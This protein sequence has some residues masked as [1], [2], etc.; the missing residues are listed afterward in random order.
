[1][2]SIYYMVISTMKQSL[3]NIVISIIVLALGISQIF[4]YK[5]MLEIQEPEPYIEYEE[6][7]TFFD[8]S[9]E[10]GLMEALMYFNVQHP[11]IV[12][13]QAVLETGNFNSRICKEYNN[14]FGLYDSRRKQYYTFNHWSESVVAYVKYIQYRYLPPKDYYK[15]LQD[16]GYAE[17]PKYIDKLKIIVE[18]KTKNLDTINGKERSTRLSNK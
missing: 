13:A 17:D 9:P 18:G 7:I 12:Y 8:K 11:H 16:I 4:I 6:V 5:K 15:F 10:E 1:M 2:Q 3:F 14:L